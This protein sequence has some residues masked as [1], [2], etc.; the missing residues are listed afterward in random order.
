MPGYKGAT[1]DFLERG[2]PGPEGRRKKSLPRPPKEELERKP[3]KTAAG[4]GDGR[5]T[6][7]AGGLGAQQCSA[8]SPLHLAFFSPAREIRRRL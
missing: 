4:T 6:G 5:D 8:P 1:A 2:F 7:E 3:G